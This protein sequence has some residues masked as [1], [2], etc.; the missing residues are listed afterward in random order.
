MEAFSKRS[1]RLVARYVNE[2]ITVRGN[3]YDRAFYYCPVECRKLRSVAGIDQHVFVVAV[4]VEELLAQELRSWAPLC[5]SLRALN[6]TFE[7][8]PCGIRS[9]VHR[10][11]RES[12]FFGRRTSCKHTIF[13]QERFMFIHNANSVDP[14][15]FL[16]L[17]V[18][19]RTNRK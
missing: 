3:D 17:S 18:V 16:A 4:V 19:T 5:A 15:G 9:A 12:V 14:V 6:N 10:S 13:T 1:A 8:A 11:G 2:L 7:V